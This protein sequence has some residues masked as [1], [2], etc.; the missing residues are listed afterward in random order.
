MLEKPPQKT[1]TWK[2]FI[3]AETADDI[4]SHS[5]KAQKLFEVRKNLL[6]EIKNLNGPEL[7]QKQELLAKLEET[8]NQEVKLA[9]AEMIGGVDIVNGSP[10]E[11]LVSLKNKLKLDKVM[12]PLYSRIE[13]IINSP[14]TTP[15]RKKE[16]IGALLYYATCSV[17]DFFGFSIPIIGFVSETLSDFAISRLVRF[18]FSRM[19][20]IDPEDVDAR[21]QGLST[22]AT[23][24][25]EIVS[26]LTAGLAGNLGGT[27]MNPALF[28][29]LRKL[30][31]GET[32]RKRRQQRVVN[33]IHS[34]LAA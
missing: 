17:I 14:E 5:S 16:V 24:G 32:D 10:E 3:P 30:F 20:L 1:D 7:T 13:G 6:E 12:P 23:L 26:P 34:E 9:V 4:K 18:S 29:L 31:P 8:I 33:K 27:F 19:G 11:I 15:S 28:Y 25:L 2:E 22:M 21:D